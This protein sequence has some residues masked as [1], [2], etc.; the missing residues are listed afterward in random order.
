M[1]PFR[2][3]RPLADAASAALLVA[4]LAGATGCGREGDAAD[5][6]TG[7]AASATKGGPGG[8]PGGGPGG[9]SSAVVLATTDVATAERG[10]I[11]AGTAITGD[12]TPIEEVTVRARLE[13]DLQEVLVREGDR[14]GQGQ[15]L[16]RFEST[17]EESDRA[18]A[19]ADRAAATSEL[20]TARWNA[21]QA[22]ELFQ[23]GAI[24]E[25]AYRAAQQGAI[26]AQAR[27]AAADARLR[28]TG[29]QE[30]DTRVLAPTAGVIG[31]RLVE[32]GEHVARG[33]SLFTVVRNDRLE[34]RADVPARQA[35]AI[36]PGQVVRFMADGTAL[37]GRVARVSPTVNPAT[38]AVAIYVQVDNPGG[39][40]KG[41]TFATGRIIGQVVPDA[42]LVP[43]AAIR[44]SGDA[45]PP[46][47]YRMAGD[48]LERAE[49]SVGVVD[50][51][52]GVAQIADGIDVG[53]RIVVGN[54]GAIGAGSRVQIVGERQTPAATAPAPS[55][56]PSAAPAPAARP[57]TGARRPEVR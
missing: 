54:V 34:L 21:D 13:G 25:Q 16:A 27:L 24:S 50:E 1:P 28:S 48:R 7:M 30:R 17:L 49:V 22:Q 55:A 35:N 44:Q 4:L 3:R 19:E 57:D 46:F 33:A 20:T 31:Q 15:L 9:G 52:R 37:E 40:L 5:A 10:S 18:S 53:D 51:V 32:R 36:R 23:A 43:V 38:R 39:R 41:N 45:E 26:A 11:E 2:L 12:L 42:V 14:V 29:R 6:A 47:I 56:A 8:R